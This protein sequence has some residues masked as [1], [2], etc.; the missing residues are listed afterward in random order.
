M[1]N[2]YIDRLISRLKTDTVFINTD[3]GISR[4]YTLVDKDSDSLHKVWCLVHDRFESINPSS[5]INYIIHDE[6]SAELVQKARDAIANAPTDHISSEDI[7]R[8]YF[9]TDIDDRTFNVLQEFK[10][11]INIDHLR[12]DKLTAV[13]F[14]AACDV[15]MDKIREARDVALKELDELEEEAKNDDTLE[16]DDLEDIE[17]IKQMFRDIPQDTDLSQYD[18]I[19]QLI[20]F[21]PS[22]LLPAPLLIG[23]LYQ[24]LRLIHHI[25]AEP[26]HVAHLTEIV[27]DISDVSVLKEFLTELD[28][29]ADS[30]NVQLAR[31]KISERLQQLQPAE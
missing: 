26:P 20:Q 5:I 17:T 18:S 23:E 29:V 21:W 6:G 31:A 3:N 28:S 24:S 9:R 1:D 27:N 2:S 13:E 8:L 25:D 14:N 4:P 22:L 11:T 10:F 7:E 30:E 12:D 16:T 19:E 15:W